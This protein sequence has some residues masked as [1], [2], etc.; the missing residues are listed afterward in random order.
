[1][2]AWEIIGACVGSSAF[3]SFITYLL[4]IRITKKKGELDNESTAIH[5]LEEV[6]KELREDKKSIISD[7]DEFEQKY[8]NEL[9]AKDSLISENTLL[10]QNICV[11]FGCALRKPSRGLGAKWVDT[12]ID[13]ETMGGDYQ[14]FNVLIKQYGKDKPEILRK[15]LSQ[16]MEQ[17]ED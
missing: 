1:M 10:K 15:A 7:R 17:S 14:P 9:K 2:N 8:E 5:T 12:H 16:D 4:T 13:D 6:I 3:F 11:H